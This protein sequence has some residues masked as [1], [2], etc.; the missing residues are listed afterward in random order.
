MFNVNL[1]CSYLTHTMVP[2]NLG[3]TH[4]QG[5]QVEKENL[6]ENECVLFYSMFLGNE[7][8]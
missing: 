6:E 3:D 8:C 7:D 5:A 4:A 1:H 2:E